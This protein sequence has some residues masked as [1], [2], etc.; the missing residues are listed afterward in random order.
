MGFLRKLAGWFG[1]IETV[2]RAAVT[3][4]RQLTQLKTAYRHFCA[5]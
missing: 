3:L 5:A 1:V 2:V 4:F